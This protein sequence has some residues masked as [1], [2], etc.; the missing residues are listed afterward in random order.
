MPNKI[1]DVHVIE[2]ADIGNDNL[3]TALMADGFRIISYQ[4]RQEVATL[5][6]AENPELMLLILSGEHSGGLACCR[7]FRTAYPGCALCLLHDDLSEWE[8]S[9]ALELG[10]DVVLRRPVEDRRILAQLRALQR[11]G[12]HAAMA[13]LHLQSGSR[14]ARVN[15]RTILLTDAE[16]ELLGILAAQT[17]QVVSRDTISQHLRGLA[18]NHSDRAIDLRIARIRQKLG[19]NAHDPRFIRTVRGEGYLLMTDDS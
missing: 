1:Q 8:E 11:R 4:F 19:D 18:H 9:I 3:K 15:G 10:A 6:A 2:F 5:P 14:T 16:F 12:G 17:G 7:N 13:R